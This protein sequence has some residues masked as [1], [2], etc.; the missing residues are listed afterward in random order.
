MIRALLAGVR[1]R[2][3][4]LFPL[5]ITKITKTHNTETC[6]DKHKIGRKEQDDHAIESGTRAAAA[7]SQGLFAPE[8]VAV[9]GPPVRKGDPV[10]IDADEALKKFNPEKLVQL[11]PCF[12]KD[13]GTVTAGNA[14]P[15]SDGAAALVL[16]S[17]AAVEK[18]A[19]KAIGRVVG[20]A[21]GA[22][23]PVDFPTAPAIAIKRAIQDAGLEPEDID[24]YEINEAFSV[25]DLANR[26]L[27]D[28]GPDK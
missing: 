12:R 10:Q 26:K 2:C 9:P 21:D 16:A 23:E 8:I 1:A 3:P 17:S 19:A 15:I 11:R 22:H 5:E 24:F 7:A 25:V 28:L 14:S 6:A 4:S 18:H 13:G 27:L 20:Y